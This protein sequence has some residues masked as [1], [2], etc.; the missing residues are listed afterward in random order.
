MRFFE[1]I[2]YERKKA[3]EEVLN[4]KSLERLFDV[5]ENENY[6]YTYQKELEFYDA[7]KNGNLVLVETLM[8]ESYFNDYVVRT[9]DS[10]RKLKNFGIIAVSVATRAAIEGGVPQDLAF[11]LNETYVDMIESYNIEKDI[12]F[13]QQ[14][15]IYDFTKRVISYQKRNYSQPINE[16]ISYIQRHIHK[17]I[18]TENLANQTG[19]SARQLARKFRSELSCSIV[20]YI[21]YEKIE[22]AKRLLEFS[23]HSIL[24]IGYLLDFCS[25][26]YFISIFKKQV[27][28][29]PARYRENK[30]RSFI[31]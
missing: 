15:C 9:Y 28:V 3:L 13:L 14:F 24:E 1:S 4:R 8:E 5:R 11:A 6:Q 19:L 25:Q 20:E 7:I 10:L 16:C 26:S 31:S 29:T 21:Q 23:S 12:I 22:E 2:D 30:K 27:G 18:T 17:R